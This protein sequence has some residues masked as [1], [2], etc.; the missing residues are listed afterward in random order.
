[1]FSDASETLSIGAARALNERVYCELLVHH[2]LDHHV[3]MSC[4]DGA[5]TL[6]FAHNTPPDSSRLAA[7]KKR[8]GCTKRCDLTMGGR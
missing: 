1:M 4:T 2:Q 5:N 8:R 6:E 3:A 7:E